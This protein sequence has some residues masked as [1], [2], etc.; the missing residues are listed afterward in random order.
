MAFRGSGPPEPPLDTLAKVLVPRGVE[1]EDV[2]GLRY[3]GFWRGDRSTRYQ[4]IVS[5]FEELAEDEDPNVKAV[6]AAGIRIFISARD[7]AAADERQQRIRGERGLG[8]GIIRGS[9]G[10]R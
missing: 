2:A 7:E 3:A 10:R 4:S 1:P 5:S 6:A 8:V 9:R